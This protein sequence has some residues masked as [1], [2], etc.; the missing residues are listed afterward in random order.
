[1]RYIG[2]Y[3]YPL[4][5]LLQNNRLPIAFDGSLTDYQMMCNLRVDVNI[6][7]EN[8]ANYID[9]YKEY[10]DNAIAQLQAYIDGDFKNQLEQY[11]DNAISDLQTEWTAYKNQV[12]TE[13][14]T[15]RQELMQMNEN[16]YYLILAKLEQFEQKILDMISG[17]GI[18]VYNPVT[19]QYTDVNTVIQD[20]YAVLRYQAFTAFEF[21]TSGITCDAFDDS[22]ITCTEYDLYGKEILG[23]KMCDC[24]VHSPFTGLVSSV[25]D[26]FEDVVATFGNGMTAAYFDNTY[27]PTATAFDNAQKTAGEFDF[28]SGV[29]VLHEGTGEF[30]ITD[31]E[32]TTLTISEG[33]QINYKYIDYPGY[34]LIS[35]YGLLQFSNSEKT[36]LN[37]LL[38]L[39]NLE[40]P[41]EFYSGA[42]S[43]G[44]AA[45]SYFAN[46]N[47]SASYYYTTTS[48][49]LRIYGSKNYFYT[50]LNLYP[51]ANYAIR[52]PFSITLIRPLS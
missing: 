48:L 38:N 39:I 28:S 13:L 17:Q 9:D 35:I 36:D 23:T 29:G 25:Q 47:E 12:D 49:Q 4:G 33:S 34:R 27:A 5:W 46:T 24:Y 52:I 30:V 21:D 15:M 14:N 41:E 32:N 19:G 6:A 37:T 22:E 1:M 16:N 3:A 42:I 43:N 8:I 40:F 7:L 50:Y 10:T 20:M 44:G 31:S 11:T 51:A 26:V 18:I 45:T 2:G